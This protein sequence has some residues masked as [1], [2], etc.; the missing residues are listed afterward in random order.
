MKATMNIESTASC[1]RSR[2]QVCVLLLAG[3]LLFSGAAIAQPQLNFK[4]LHNNWPE[5]Q[6]D[7]ETSCN[8]QPAYVSSDRNYRVFENGVEIRDFTLWCP[9]VVGR[10]TI[11]V[12]LVLDASGSMMGAGNAGARAAG[13]AFV[14]MMDGINDEAAILWAGAA[15]FVAQ[16]MTT[17]LDLLHGAVDSLPAADSSAI[18]DGMYFGL[19]ELIRNSVN[20]CRA[21]IVMS[22][23]ADNFSS[24]TPEEVIALAKLHRIKVYT[25]GLGAGIQSD[26]L[27]DIAAQ[28]G[29]RYYETP[30]PSQLT[31]I[32]QE[33]SYYVFPGPYECVIF[34]RSNC[35]DGGNRTVDLSLV[36]F[37][38][39]QDTK[40]KTYKAPKDTSTF[41]PLRF[42]IAKR[43]ARANTDVTV[44]LEL[45]DSVSNEMLNASTFAIQFD[46][47]LL[48]FKAI[49]T[50]PGSALEGVPIS[51]V[52]HG[53]TIIVRTLDKKLIDVHTASATLFE[54]SFTAADS[55]R[56][57]TVCSP[58]RL[59][60]WSFEAGCFRPVLTDGEVC[61][62]PKQSTG[63]SETRPPLPRLD[64]YP[65]PAGDRL[66]VSA[67]DLRGGT[68]RL[69]VS[70]LIGRGVFSGSTRSGTIE[71]RLICRLCRRVCMSCACM[72]R[73]E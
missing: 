38:N 36:N 64:L 16:G 69:I 9:D 32:Y 73:M 31:A 19:Q 24:H 61:I 45:R 14:D 11:S 18:W 56:K 66:T 20:P 39:G 30:S 65:Q 63:V 41:Q 27:K 25:I 33:I 57:D 15:P 7:F 40:T 6:L 2:L 58:L 67:R 21:M 48:R 3:V 52:E 59:L 5:I 51:V 22:D 44:P 8:A 54:L 46:T 68:H 37:C 47:S 71:R 50:P 70:D 49:T 35:A 53:D 26:T 34:Y 72:E 23:G 43:E 10:C 62:H 60:S 13:N 28:T 4:R 12:S 42:G 1:L 55:D 17:Y 29:G